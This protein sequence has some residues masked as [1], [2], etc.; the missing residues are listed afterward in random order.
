M[1]RAE[2]AAFYE[3]A[4]AF[5][6]RA[7]DLIDGKPAGEVAAA[8]LYACARF[9]A[10]AV[11][12]QSGGPAGVDDEAVDY[13]TGEFESHLRDHMEMPAGPGPGSRVDPTG[14]PADGPGQ[15]VRVLRALDGRLEA[16]VSDFL[17]LADRFMDIANGLL[18]RAR[19]NRISAA[20]MHAS[21]RFNVF[22]MHRP[23]H[24]AEVVEE[25]LVAD[26]CAIY[27]SLVR[28]HGGETL[29]GPDA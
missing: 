11:Q 3:M 27:A 21:A 1:S 4:D 20:F 26:Y 18:D 12:V 19:S 13:L 23:G 15:A 29:I 17:T 14:D 7:N 10:F 8:M 6:E 25:A 2:W 24:L 22:A 5:I 9:N 16:E 28:Y